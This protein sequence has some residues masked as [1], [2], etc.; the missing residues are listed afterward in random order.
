VLDSATGSF[1]QSG[2]EYGARDGL[3]ATSAHLF[4]ITGGR[5]TSLTMYG[6]RARAFADLDLEE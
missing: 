5:V 3:I 4:D 6:D 2:I 1:K